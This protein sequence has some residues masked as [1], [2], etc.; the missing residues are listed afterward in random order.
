MK[1]ALIT[2]TINIPRGLSLYRAHDPDVMFF[3]AGDLKTPEPQCAD[4]VNT[5]GQRVADTPIASLKAAFS[6][7]EGQAARVA[8][9]IHCCRVA[10]QEDMRAD[11]IGVDAVKQGIEIAW[12]MMLEAQR[13]YTEFGW[14]AAPDRSV[15]DKVLRVL[16]NA[17]A[18]L[19]ATEIHRV[20]S[21]HHKGPVLRAALAR[22][23]AK[24]KARSAKDA[25][26]TR[27][28]AV[29]EVQQ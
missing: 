10:S 12:W 6:K 4:F 2:T 1:V 24:G 11:V 28:S 19:T 13:I 8:L 14:A 26:A 22:L 21:N 7:I 15:D 17:P 3:V 25:K 5:L 23:E 29:M 18:G 16:R 9:L 27:W 20:T